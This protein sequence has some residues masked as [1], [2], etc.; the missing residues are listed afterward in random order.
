MYAKLSS[1]GGFWKQ[2]C[3]KEHLMEYTVLRNPEEPDKKTYCGELLHDIQIPE[4]TTWWRKVFL[5]GVQMRRNICQGRFELWRLFLTSPEHVPVKHMTSDTTFRELRSSHRRSPFNHPERRV[6]LHRYWN[7]DYLLLIS[8]SRVNRFMDVFVWSWK[9]C[10]NPVFLYSKDLY[11]QY[12]TGLF[13]TAFFVSKSYFVLMP[14]PVVDGGLETVRS[15]IRVHDISDNMKLVGQYDFPDIKGRR[16]HVRHT[17]TYGHESGHL[18]KVGNLAV[19]LCRTPELNVFVFSLPDCQLIREVS[20][21][22]VISSDLQNVNLDQRFHLY[23][24][25][26]MFMLHENDFYGFS[27]DEEDYEEEKFGKLLTIDLSNIVAGRKDDHVEVKLDAQ[28][29]SS[30]DYVEKMFVMSKNKVICSLNSGRIQVRELFNFGSSFRILAQVA[31]PEILKDE[32]GSE[33]SS[34]VEIDGPFLCVS[35]S[36]KKVVEMRHFQSARKIYVYSLEDN[37]FHFMFSINLDD[38]VFGLSVTPSQ[39]SLDFDGNFLCVADLE[40]VLIWNIN[41]GKFVRTIPIPKHYN[42]KEDRDEIE[43]K[44]CWKG[45][46]DFAFAEDGI[47]IVHSQ[48][49]FPAAADI[50]LFW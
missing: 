47:I 29:D 23:E 13:P 39:M 12:P 45:H 24:N 14:N 2:I 49:N 37:L 36:G 33:H 28:F 34:E 16:R 4:E 18:H 6:R 46:T 17:N 26:V 30:K 22:A 31:P 3:I 38:S 1:A 20:L 5:R 27:E 43:D 48:R 25:T 19:A 9:E 7:E 50:M 44:F 21:S 35:R 8:Q 10:Q 41:N 32:F 42:V 40:K 11:S 15:M